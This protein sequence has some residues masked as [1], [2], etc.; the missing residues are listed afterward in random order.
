VTAS[1]LPVKNQLLAEKS[2][3]EKLFSPNVRR[4]YEQIFTALLVDRDH[5]I[6]IVIQLS[7]SMGTGC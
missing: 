5:N 3:C 4:L 2:I 1:H 7:R 6:F